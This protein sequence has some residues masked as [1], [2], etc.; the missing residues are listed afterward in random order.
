MNFVINKDY[1]L[2]HLLG[3]LFF[4]SAVNDI[5]QSTLILSISIVIA[6][7][8]FLFKF[9]FTSFTIKKQLH[10][11]LFLLLTIAAIINIVFIDNGLG[12][13]FV[14]LTNLIIAYLYVEFKDKK[15]LTLAILISFLFIAFNLFYKIVILGIPVNELYLNLSRNHGNFVLLFWSVFALFHIYITYNKV[16]LIIPLINLFIAIFLVGRTGIILGILL[17]FVV[18]VVKFSRNFALSTISLLIV[19]VYL[20]INVDFFLVES[21]FVY[22]T[23]LGQ[24]LETSRW[25]LWSEYIHSINF[26]SLLI[27]VDVSQLPLINSYS[28]NPHNSFLKFHSRVGIGSFSIFFYFFLSV[29]SYIKNKDFFVL[30]LLILLTVRAFF[31]SDLL[32]GYFD[33]IFFSIIFY[34]SKFFSFK[35]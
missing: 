10:I 30:S 6:L 9:T 34:S 1:I 17:L 21:F 35:L 13:T 12:G 18:S 33:F 32:I 25:D 23:N 28:N 31:D 7:I 8:A 24:G 11:L 15:N 14:L 2:G 5:L 26:S 20:L 3:L 19:L 29:Y 22:E 4:L 16:S 27:G